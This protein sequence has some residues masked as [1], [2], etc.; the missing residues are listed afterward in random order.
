VHAA[1]WSA[2]ASP[3]PA[4]VLL[5]SAGAFACFQS[6]L[7]TGPAVPVI[8]LMTAA[9][10]VAAV[11]IGLLAFGEPLGSGTASAALHAVAFALAG[12]AGLRL[13]TAQTR[14]APDAEAPSRA[15]SATTSAPSA[16]ASACSTPA[17][18]SGGP[19][20]HSSAPTAASAPISTL[21]RV[22]RIRAA[23]S[24]PATPSHT[25]EMP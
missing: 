5:L 16:N 20:I 15:R 1:G 4:A 19:A 8:A 22:P 24:A 9:T 17:R 21:G 10:N 3:W 6:G 7:Q 23:T 18:S 12:A 25:H 11:L 13:A 14:L 2:L